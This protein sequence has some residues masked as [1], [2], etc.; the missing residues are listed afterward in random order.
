METRIDHIY[1]QHKL[2]TLCGEENNPEQ[3]KNGMLWSDGTKLN[4]YLWRKDRHANILPIGGG[5]GFFA[6]SFGRPPKKL[7]PECYS[8][9]IL[10]AA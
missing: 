1:D 7:C 10:V 6:T 8:L 5:D 2:A 4:W 9:H 3:L